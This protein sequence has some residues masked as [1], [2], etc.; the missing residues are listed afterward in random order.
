MLLA[1]QQ[2]PSTFAQNTYAHNGTEHTKCG[3]RRIEKMSSFALEC[4]GTVQ[5]LLSNIDVAS[6]I[7]LFEHFLL[8]PARDT[9]HRTPRSFYKFSTLYTLYCTCLLGFGCGFGH[10]GCFGALDGL[11]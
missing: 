7:F 3:T 2:I 9:L 10:F 8:F 4:R 11:L 6:C 1:V 5:Y